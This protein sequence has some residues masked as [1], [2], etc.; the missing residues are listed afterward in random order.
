VAFIAA[1][2]PEQLTEILD[3][4]FPLWGEGLDRAGY[5]RYNVA[6]RETRWGSRHLQRLVLSDGRRW[7]S[8]AKRYELEGRLDGRDVRIL[9]IGAIFTPTEARRRGHAAD[10]VRRM[11]DQAAGERF[12]LA[13][14][15][16][17]IGTSYY[18]SLGFVPLPLA[19]V[20]LVVEPLRGPAAI[21][22]RSGEAGDIRAICDMNAGQASAFRFSMKRRPEYA[23]FALAKKR[24]LA[25]AGAR[26]HREVEFFVVEEGG[27]AAAYL[28]LL[29][30][31]RH[32]MVTE[33]GDRDPSGARVGAILQT[34]LAD[35]ERRPVHIRAWLPGP[36]LPP[37][38]RVEA[39]E[40]PALVMMACPLGAT[41]IDPPLGEGDLAWWHADAF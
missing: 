7:L 38:V 37:Q 40:V 12:D 34:L 20:R 36:F 8:S 6:Q 30:V 17:E 15:F 19:Q 23:A 3:E 29:E 35:P 33:C 9:G 2:T 39:R 32:W 25:A 14:L 5:E 1:A 22:L 16:S 31:G 28:V 11:L 21:A 13:L 10:L 4:T 27:R 41:R 18:A 24:L 26:G